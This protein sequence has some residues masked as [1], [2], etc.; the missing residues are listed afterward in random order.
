[1][2]FHKNLFGAD[3]VHAVLERVELLAHQVVDGG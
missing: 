3:D 2:L 1:M